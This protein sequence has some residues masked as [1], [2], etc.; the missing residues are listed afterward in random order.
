MKRSSSW[1]QNGCLIT[2]PVLRLGTHPEMER[3]AMREQINALYFRC[4]HE[5]PRRD[6]VRPSSAIPMVCQFPRLG[7]QFTAFEASIP[8]GERF[9]QEFLSWCSRLR[10]MFHVCG[11]D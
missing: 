2:V 10:A 1:L 9:F 3:P 8:D 5:H 7:R 11:P 4:D 6:L